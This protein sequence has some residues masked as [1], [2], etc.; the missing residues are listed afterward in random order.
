[1]FS[2]VLTDFVWWLFRTEIQQILQQSLCLASREI[3]PNL[4]VTNNLVAQSQPVCGEDV[5]SVTIDRHDISNKTMLDTLLI[6]VSTLGM[7]IKETTIF[8]TT[9]VKVS[10]SVGQA[11]VPSTQ[12]SLKLPLLHTRILAVQAVGQA[13]CLHPKLSDCQIMPINS[14]S[15]FCCKMY[16]LIAFMLQQCSWM[17]HPTNRST[18]GMMYIT[19]AFAS[20]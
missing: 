11:A 2:C 14:F 7:Q 19:H 9:R 6:F 1:M 18:Q 3:Y 8:K 10:R 17:K 13:S 15:P 5:M 4:G 16:A 12:N 20:T